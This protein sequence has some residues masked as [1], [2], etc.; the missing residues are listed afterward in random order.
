MQRDEPPS[1]K[2]R[3]SSLDDD[4]KELVQAL[5]EA[6]KVRRKLAEE[7]HRIKV[8]RLGSSN[9][10]STQSGPQFAESSN[11]DQKTFTVFVLDTEIRLF[12][13]GKLSVTKAHTFTSHTVNITDARNAA[14]QI[15]TCLDAQLFLTCT[16]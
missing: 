5:Q 6:D 7:H 15:C 10:V 3:V 8:P 16:K 13:A 4:T 11:P 14:D 2:V 12:A 9:V 1:K